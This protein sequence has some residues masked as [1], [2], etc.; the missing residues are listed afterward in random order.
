MG[1][2][3]L[4][5]CKIYHVAR[6]G[7]RHLCEHIFMHVDQSSSRGSLAPLLAAAAAVVDVN[8]IAIA[9]G[10]VRFSTGIQTY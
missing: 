1:L 6:G 2:Q 7:Y 3:R 10:I 4:R 8:H 5:R 9:V